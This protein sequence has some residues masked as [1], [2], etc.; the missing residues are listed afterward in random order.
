MLKAANIKV[1][2][3]TEET[4]RLG[5]FKRMQINVKEEKRMH[6]QYIR[7]TDEFTDKDKTWGWLKNGDL[8]LPQKH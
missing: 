3:K 8:K 6:C 5:E 7:E 1:I 2:I 4:V